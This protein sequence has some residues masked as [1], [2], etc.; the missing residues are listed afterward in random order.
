MV[1]LKSALSLNLL[2]MPIATSM[3]KNLS[4][5][6]EHVVQ[7]DAVFSSLTCECNE[8]TFVCDLDREGC[9]LEMLETS[10][11]EFVKTG[12]TGG[13]SSRILFMQIQRRRGFVFT[14][15]FNRWTRFVR[16]SSFS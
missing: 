7:I 16:R 6:H 9:Q 3:Q 4:S 5:E 1:F 10:K 13:G 8:V 14:R 11:P 2:V 15:K 12:Q